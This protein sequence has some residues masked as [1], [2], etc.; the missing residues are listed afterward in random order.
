MIQ[1]IQSLYFSLTIILSLLF[2]KGSFL[3]FI[4]EPGSVTKVTFSRIIS[5][6]GEQGFALINW[7][8]PLSV[9]IIIIPIL[10]LIT[11]FLYKRRPIQK[12]LAITGIFLAAGFSLLIAIYSYS[13]CSR[14]EMKLV[15]TWKMILPV[16][17][18]VFYLL[19]YRGI[20]KDD[21]LVKSYDRLR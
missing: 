6:T 12:V 1:R 16:L 10:S 17:I 15:L 20:V 11:I 9:F 3:T 13:I 18:L 21:H 8:L 14:N 19:A 4:N 2:L 7:P 5:V